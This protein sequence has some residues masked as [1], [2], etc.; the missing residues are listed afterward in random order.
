MGVGLLLV[1]ACFIF[2][3]FI[4]LI[5]FLPDFIGY[6][7]ILCGL[8]KLSD[9]DI[10]VFEAR[11]RMS[12][13]LWVAVGRFVVMLMSLLLRFDSTL[14]LV[15]AFSLAVLEIMFVIPAFSSFF[16]SFEYMQLRFSEDF[17][18]SK[19]ENLKKMTTVFLAVRSVGAVIPEFTSLS[20][21]YGD[22]VS[23][24]GHR[25]NITVVRTLLIGL[26]FA[27]ALVFG[28]IWL[29]MMAGY[30]KT[31]MANKD[32]IKFLQFKYDTE[33]KTDG[34]L[35][36][37][38]RVK[39]FQKL[40]FISVFF[41]ICIPF[42]SFYVFPEFLLGVLMIFAFLLSGKYTEDKKSAVIISSLYTLFS[43]M[44]YAF[45]IRYSLNLG[46]VIFPY[47]KAGFMSFYLPYTV[48]GALSYL[49]MAIVF[50]EYKKTSVNM[51]NVCVGVGDID[52][53]RRKEI[54]E[55]RKKSL[56]KKN[57]RLFGFEI[58]YC[59]ASIVFMALIPYLET[60]WIFRSALWVILAVI[61]YSFVFDV[62]AEA[63]KAL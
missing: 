11:R 32:Y 26:C 59:I 56:V 3:P 46:D 13:A 21:E 38:R 7:F 35:M 5:D 15:F 25:M 17:R 63:E 18:F 55:E 58:F 20:S 37:K 2:N 49:I 33:V 4:G 36:M 30:L 53:I 54:N 41:L 60:A 48:C 47:Q 9:V 16:E 10:K 14:V 62:S 39:I 44:E 34:V 31:V 52:D 57:T 1:G 50:F 23:G 40:S 42:N 51:I 22:V 8:S 28:I 27:A 29:S 12:N 6:I 61:M 24:G 45:L 43:V 19:I